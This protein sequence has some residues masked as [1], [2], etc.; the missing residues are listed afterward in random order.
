MIP[1]PEYLAIANNIAALLGSSAFALV[2]IIQIALWHDVSGEYALDNIKTGFM[3]LGIAAV[4]FIL[5]IY[6]FAFLCLGMFTYTAWALVR[7]A[8][9]IWEER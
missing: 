2:G 8:T 1:V 9:R 5:G 4:L 3:F 6:A 7:A